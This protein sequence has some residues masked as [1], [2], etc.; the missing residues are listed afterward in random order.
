MAKPKESAAS[1]AA[2]S[3]IADLKGKR[4]VS[5]SEAEQGHRL[6]LGKVKYLT[7]LGQL[8]ARYL[9]ENFFNFK[10]THKLFLDCNHKPTVSDPNDAIWNRLKLVPFQ[11]E[12][13]EPDTD[14]PNKLRAELPGILRWIVEGAVEYCRNGIGAAPDEVMEAT[15]AYRQESDKLKDFIEEKCIMGDPKDY[16]LVA[17]LYPAYAAWAENAGEKFVLPKSVFDDRME[18]LGLFKGKDPA[19]L[20]RAWRGIKFQ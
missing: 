10:P 15:E 9:C 8:R 16:I 2:N 19:G 4:F 11:V 17:N 13:L 6:S 20:K 7:G 1:N 14:M 12:I 18:N 3:D 5:S